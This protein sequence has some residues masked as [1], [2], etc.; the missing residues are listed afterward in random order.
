MKTRIMLILCSAF[1]TV[2]MF[3]TAPSSLAQQTN[4]VTSVPVRIAVTANVAS[5]KRMPQINPE[6]VVVKQGKQRLQVTEWIPAQGDRAGLDAEQFSPSLFSLVCPP[7]FYCGFAVA[8]VFA[9]VF[10]TMIFL[11]T[12]F[13]ATTFIATT[14]PRK[15]RNQA[16]P[17]GYKS[18]SDERRKSDQTSCRIGMSS[19]LSSGTSFLR[20]PRRACFYI[21]ARRRAG[22]P[23]SC[24]VE[25]AFRTN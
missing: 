18:E 16:Q 9:A 7:I 22:L 21:Q 14:H 2:A 19:S 8:L 10:F 23:A 15:P 11:A 3:V 1:A 17:V 6:D 24:S 13:L 12:I 25:H 5:D 20:G 4:T